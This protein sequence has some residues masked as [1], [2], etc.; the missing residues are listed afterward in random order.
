MAKLAAPYVSRRGG[1]RSAAASV[2]N[3]GVQV[4]EADWARAVAANP[5]L[6]SKDKAERAETTRKE[7][8]TGSLAKYRRR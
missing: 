7:I 3:E 5:G 4:P 1:G 2:F 6:E 8:L